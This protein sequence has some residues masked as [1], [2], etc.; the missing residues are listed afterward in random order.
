MRENS[1]QER[2]RRKSAKQEQHLQATVDGK[3]A[4]ENLSVSSETLREKSGQNSETIQHP[5]TSKAKIFLYSMNRLNLTL[6]S[7]NTFLRGDHALHKVANLQ[8]IWCGRFIINSVQEWQPTLST[9][10]IQDLP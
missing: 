10:R 7:N 6:T 5:T 2:L 8:S 1:L 9:L 3:S 4:L